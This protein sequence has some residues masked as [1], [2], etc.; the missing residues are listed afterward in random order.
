MRT[1]CNL[2]ITGVASL[3]AHRSQD[4]IPWAVKSQ[5]REGDPYGQASGAFGDINMRESR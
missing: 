4:Q 2:L 5:L 1:A 3:I